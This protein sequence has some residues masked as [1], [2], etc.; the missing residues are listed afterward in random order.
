MAGADVFIGTSVGGVL[1]PEL[2]SR[3][4]PIPIVFALANPEPE[5]QPE[6]IEGVAAVIATGRSDYPNQINN[7]LCFPGF[8]RGLL[9]SGAQQ[10]TDGMKLAARARSPVWSVT[11]STRSTSSRRCSIATSRQRSPPR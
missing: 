4:A 11:T 9:D 10:I 8:F 6:A 5:V 1:D 7:V 2:V 3:M